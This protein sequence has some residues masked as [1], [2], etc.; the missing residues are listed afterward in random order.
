[1]ETKQLSPAVK[2]VFISLVLILVGLVIYFT[3]Q[4]QNKPL[5]WLQSLLFGAGII[6]ACI[7]YANANNGN[8]T[9]GNVFANGF[10]T[11]A[12]ATAIFMVYTFISIK[13]IMPDIIDIAMEEARKGMVEKNMPAEQIDQAMQM[14]QKFF[15]PFAV[16]GS[17]L[18]YLILGLIF[19]LI[20]GAVAKKNP[21]PS[22]FDQQ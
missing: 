18:T 6:W 11:A 8:V 19:S 7:N 21:N 10:K 3:G 15:V 13:Y 1:M 14:M 5:A 20:G 12:A 4:T 16:G 9:F 2:G 22:P 17:L